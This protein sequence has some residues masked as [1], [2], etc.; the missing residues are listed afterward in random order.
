M[1]RE[2]HSSVCVKFFEI[3]AKSEFTYSGQKC[4]LIRLFNRFFFKDW[5]FVKLKG[6]N[7]LKKD[8]INL[9]TK[10]LFQKT[11]KSNLSNFAFQYHRFHQFKHK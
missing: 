11:F 2:V 4:C 5:S 7:L 3:A 8:Y 6:K 10:I 9:K 1:K